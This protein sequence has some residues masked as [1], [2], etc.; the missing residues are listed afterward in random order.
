MEVHCNE[1]AL[2]KIFIFT[3]IKSPFDTTFIP[4]LQVYRVMQHILDSQIIKNQQMH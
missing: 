3:S 2:M 1:F 4:L